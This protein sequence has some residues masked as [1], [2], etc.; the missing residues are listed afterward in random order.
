MSSSGKK[1]STAKTVSSS[2]KKCRPGLLRSR[3]SALA[4]A[5][6]NETD[7]SLELAVAKREEENGG[8]ER[9]FRLGGKR[10]RSIEI[11][12]VAERARRAASPFSLFAS[13]S[14]SHPCDLSP[15]NRPLLSKTH[16]NSDAQPDLP[17]LQAAL[18][19]LVFFLIFCQLVIEENNNTTKKE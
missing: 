11:R 2:A 16:T 12:D 8:K 10:K 5:L 18:G 15:K 13:L 3:P 14:L 1:V 6:L 17:L 7:D 4:Q 9:T 19:S